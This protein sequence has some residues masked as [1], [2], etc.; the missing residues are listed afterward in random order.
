MP[1]FAE[2]IQASEEAHGE[3][4]LAK[5]VMA[6]IALA[7]MPGYGIRRP[8]GGSGKWFR[9]NAVGKGGTSAD[10][11]QDDDRHE[12]GRQRSH[13]AEVAGTK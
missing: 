8:R 13:F 7:E 4:P 1:R 11:Y 12:D 9:W 2:D 3:D 5:E 6:R 10:D